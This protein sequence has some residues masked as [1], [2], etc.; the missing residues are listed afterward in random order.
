MSAKSYVKTHRFYRYRHSSKKGWVSFQVKYRETDLWIRAR[1]N[2]EK[3][4]TEAVL[5]CRNR[6]ERYIADH[7]TFLTSLTPLPDD[8]LAPPLVREMLSA[9]SA[10]DVGPM[11]SVAGAI[12][13]AVAVALRPLAPSIVVENGGDCYLDLQEETVVG[14]FA[15]PS[16]PFT[17][18]IG[19]RFSS[20][21]FP[22]GICTSSGTVGHSLSFGKADAVTVIS[23]NAALADAAATRLG[24][25]VSAPA[26]IAAALDCA[27]SL[28]GIEGV[29]ITIRDKMGLWGDLELV[30]L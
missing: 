2:L 4:A 3:E 20:D 17:G 18:K 25:I 15:G 24:N 13:Q 6:L 26:D 19:L 8:P 27:P 9:A 21:R 1:R 30:R 28:P 7:P 29:L 22:L 12:A 10:V 5:N 23:R 11:A 16:S 14:I